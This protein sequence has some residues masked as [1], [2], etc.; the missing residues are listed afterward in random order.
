MECYCC[1]GC[2]QEAD[3][4]E[5]TGGSI[6]DAANQEAAFALHDSIGQMCKELL[7]ELLCANNV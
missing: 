6:S 3:L 7:S 5:S 2:G 4:E 1:C